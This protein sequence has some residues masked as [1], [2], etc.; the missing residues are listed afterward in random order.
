[1]NSTGN[2][3]NAGNAAPAP[4][5]RRVPFGPIAVVLS[6]VTLLVMARL[7]FNHFSGWDDN[8]TIY[9]NPRLNPPTL[10]AIPYYFHHF[11]MRIYAP[12]TF[13]AWTA[14]AL[15]ARVPQ[16]RNGISLDPLVFHSANVLLHLLAVLV[17][18]KILLLMRFNWI[19]AL[20]GSL[21]FAVHPVQV[22]PVAWASGLK[23]VLSGL[24]ALTALWQYVRFAIDANAGDRR[25]GPL[26]ICFVALI[27]AM[28]AKTSAASVPLA[29]IVLDLLIV[30][31]PWKS[32]LATAGFL[33]IAAAPFIF[34][35]STAQA[36]DK[37]LTIP[38]WHR[39]LIAADCLAFYT[40]KLLWPI[41]L[42]IDYGRTPRV[43][44]HQALF[45]FT[46]LVPGAIALA[47]VIVRKRAR[48]LVAAALV[49][50]AGCLPTLG[51]IP[52]SMQYYSTTADHYLYWAMLGPA[53]A[54]GWLL[55]AFPRARALRIGVVAAIVG[56][57][58]L[59]VR[60]GGFWKDDFSLFGHTISVNPGSFASYSN[61]GYA[62]Y[63]E[64]DDR[65][66]V[67]SY[68][69]CIA[70]KPEDFVAHSSLAAALRELGHL[71]EATQEL[72]RS[73]A[74]QRRQPDSLRYIWVEDLNHL[75]RNLLEAG[76]AAEAAAALRE[77]L[78]ANP[79][80]PDVIPM[81]ARADAEKHRAATSQAHPSVNR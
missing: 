74:L 29:A 72:Q 10:A 77:S 27:L 20:C 2:K 38:L 12:L 32:V 24:L 61:I 81:L 15:V 53:M 41:N 49:F 79:D 65:L 22:E 62:Y 36:V 59:S 1:M 6:S 66:A 63:R 5:A 9:H 71:D 34:I 3:P 11:E 50:F 58:I 43:A 40:F 55:T 52:L 54:V 70:I 39:P 28:L 44:A 30:Q 69:K 76:K 80:Q 75:G 33:A 17:V 57:S 4:A 73:I 8:L 19:A 64:G 31:R 67:E 23:D 60:Q 46:W 26:L 18:C 56:W 37:I 16:D 78:A 47:L 13:S 51:V 14:L 45:H 48:P 42:C 25:L 68:R 7:C 35:G 21:V